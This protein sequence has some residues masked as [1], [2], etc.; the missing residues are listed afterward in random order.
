MTD[1][2]EKT[3]Q[4]LQQIKDKRNGILRNAE[5]GQTIATDPENLPPLREGYIRLVHQTH[6][7]HTDNLVNKGLIY[8]R[9]YA[10]KPGEGGRY[11][12][13]TS[14]AIAYD[15]NEFWSSLVK[16]GIRHKGADVKA[17]FD[18]PLEECGT[19]QKEKLAQ[20]LDGTISRG[21]L[22]GVIPNYGNQDMKLSTEEME[23]KKQRSLSNPLPEKSFETPNWQ[24]N[25][26]TAWQKMEEFYASAEDNLFGHAI[27]PQETAELSTEENTAEPDNSDDTNIDWAAGGN[28][29]EEQPKQELSPAIKQAML[30]KKVN[31]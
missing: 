2:L 19:H 24:E 26:A 28:D 13:I 9:E 21:Y 7:E 31:G 25:V 1:S 18:M 22:V 15:E 17:V 5:T 27:S 11:S 8:N 30:N 16:E 29:F 3:K 12:D 23:A 10:N 6:R 14:M 4:K 20:Y